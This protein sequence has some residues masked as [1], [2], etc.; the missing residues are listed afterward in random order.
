MNKLYDE[1]YNKKSAF[2]SEFGE[3]LKKHDDR[4]NIKSFEYFVVDSCIE[5]LT[6]TFE[7]G[8]Q[9]GIDVTGDSIIALTHDIYKA[10]V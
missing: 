3:L 7:N 2:V 10:L 4:N 5:I 8:H 6:I 1:V 9:K